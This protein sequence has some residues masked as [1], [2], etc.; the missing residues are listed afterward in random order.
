MLIAAAANNPQLV[1]QSVPTP[2][3]DN[4]NNN[5]SSTS[6]STNNSYGNNTVNNSSMNYKNV[7]PFIREY[8]PPPAVQPQYRPPNAPPVNLSNNNDSQYSNSANGYNNNDNYDATNN[9][10]AEDLVIPSE[11][12]PLIDNLPPAEPAAAVTKP[13]ASAINNDNSSTNSVGFNYN[14]TDYQYD[15]SAY[16][17]SDE[18]QTTANNSKLP[19]VEKP[20]NSL[21]NN[22]ISNSNSEANSYNNNNN[23]RTS[24]PVPLKKSPSISSFLGFPGYEAGREVLMAYFL[25]TEG[26]QFL[27]TLPKFAAAYVCYTNGTL[28]KLLHRPDWHKVL[29]QNYCFHGSHYCCTSVEVTF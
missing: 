7:D 15:A 8:V 21:P 14:P 3:I 19:A 1:Q 16:S 18:S 23:S 22:A 13:L 5:Q 27:S 20:R 4:P 25:T 28:G 2:S 10:V 29:L 24:S 26:I 6:N 9:Y 12:N 17:Y 11:K